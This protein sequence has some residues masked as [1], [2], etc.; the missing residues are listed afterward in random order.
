MFTFDDDTE[1]DWKKFRVS[2]TVAGT[3]YISPTSNYLDIT[4]TLDADVTG[5]S[6]SDLS[7]IRGVVDKGWTQAVGE[8]ANTNVTFDT[9]GITVKSNVYDG[10]Y[11]R[12]TPLEFAGYD[13]KGNRAFAVNND[14][15]EVNNLEVDGNIDTQEILIVS[16]S[17]GPNAGMN[18][19]VKG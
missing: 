9:T 1:Y 11:T 17:S 5:F 12:M 2:D 8:V 7:L 16:L 18:F 3:T 14:T 19:V 6:Y 15:T 4:F 13:D 10:A